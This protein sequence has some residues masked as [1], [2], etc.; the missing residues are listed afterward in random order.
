MNDEDKKLIE[1]AERLDA[2][3]TPGPWFVGS[4]THS[5]G[6]SSDDSAGYPPTDGRLST[7]EDDPNSIADTAFI[8]GARSLL[9]KLAK[10]LREALNVPDVPPEPAKLPEPLVDGFY[11]VRSGSA[12]Q[13]AE[14]IDQHWWFT[15]HD[16]PCGIHDADVIAG[17]LQPPTVTNV[18]K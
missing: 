7:L 11:W 14:R 6:R 12:L 18:T 8:I 15:G 1:E 4:N 16:Y 9:P 10:R 2:E 3:A 17:P 13:I 5:V